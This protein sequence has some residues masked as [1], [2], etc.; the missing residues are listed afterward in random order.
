MAIFKI[1]N[2]MFFF[3]A[4]VAPTG[5]AELRA[6]R[7]YAQE[8]ALVQMDV[9]AGRRRTM[10]HGLTSD[11]VRARDSSPVR[12]PFWGK[13]PRRNEIELGRLCGS[14]RYFGMD[15]AACVLEGPRV[16]R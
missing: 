6:V 1:S 12:H 15:L 4:A 14:L 8:T 9:H 2:A 5:S 16:D 13:T 7:S 11:K 10:C 3:G